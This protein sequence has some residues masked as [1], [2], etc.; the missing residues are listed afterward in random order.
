MDLGVRLIRISSDLCA[1]LDLI[2]QTPQRRACAESL[3][4]GDDRP[5]PRH[6]REKNEQCL[7]SGRGKTKRVLEGA[8]QQRSHE[9]GEEG[10]WSDPLSLGV[11]AFQMIAEAQFKPILSG[12]D[13][14]LVKIKVNPSL[15][16]IIRSKGLGELRLGR[17][18]GITHLSLLSPC[19]PSEDPCSPHPED[20]E[21]P[22]HES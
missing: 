2:E 10:D 14:V 17:N 9:S 3:D 1:L 11:D 8:S 6:D 20:Q 7:P 13:N 5:N 16:D 4:D 15:L 18:R 12:D 19:P 21:P 22:T